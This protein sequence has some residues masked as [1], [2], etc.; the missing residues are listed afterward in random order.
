[1]LRASFTGLTYVISFY[2][3]IAHSGHVVNLSM[4]DVANW[5]L[6]M[7]INVGKATLE[8]G[9]MFEILQLDQISM[10]LTTLSG[11]LNW[12]FNTFGTFLV[13]PSFPDLLC[14]VGPADCINCLHSVMLPCKLLLTASWEC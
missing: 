4:L 7:L 8:M 5:L 6:N 11:F 14:G 9:Y 3:P 12:N 13:F 10:V 1:M 2:G